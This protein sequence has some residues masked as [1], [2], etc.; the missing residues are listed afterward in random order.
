MYNWKS[1]LV[2]HYIIRLWIN[3]LPVSK[4]GGGIL[5]VL[6]GTGRLIALQAIFWHHPNFPRAGKEKWG[7]IHMQ[8]WH[9]DHR[10][11]LGTLLADTGIKCLKIAQIERFHIWSCCNWSLM[12]TRYYI[13]FICQQNCRAADAF[14]QSAKVAKPMKI[15]NNCV[16]RAVPSFSAS[17]FS[18]CS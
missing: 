10:N 3:Q 6:I 2:A 11:W 15:R 13:W 18:N 9:L 12:M 17:V 14:S 5:K 7:D 4:N 8:Q 16:G 1:R